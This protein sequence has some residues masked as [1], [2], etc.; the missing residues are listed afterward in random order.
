MTTTTGNP[1]EDQLLNAAIDFLSDQGMPP[2]VIGGVSVRHEPEERKHNH[3]LV[4]KFTGVIKKSED[5]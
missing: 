5:E 4:I 1:F 3:E 2:I